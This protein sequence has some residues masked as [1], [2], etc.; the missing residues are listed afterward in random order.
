MSVVLGMWDSLSDDTCCFTK[1]RLFESTML[2]EVCSSLEQVQEA[3]MYDYTVSGKA[4]F[5][6]SLLA[7]SR[8]RF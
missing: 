3:Y 2:K 5:K 6:S 1:N 4:R 7:V 8:E